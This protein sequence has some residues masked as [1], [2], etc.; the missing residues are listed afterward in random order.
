MF[1]FGNQRVV[2]I[3][4]VRIG[5]EPGE[6][7]T[8]LIGS[9]FYRGHKVVRDERNGIFDRDS[10]ESLIMKIE[11]LS[12]R[13]GNPGLVDVVLMS[14]RAVEGYI[15]FVADTTDKPFLIDSALPEVR[16]SAVRYAEEVGVAERIIYNSISPESKIEELDAL[17]NSEIRSAIALTYTPRLTS[18]SSRIDAFKEL[19]PEIE[20]AGITE[21]LV[22]TFVMDVPSLPVSAVAG[23]KI[24]KAFGYPTGS[25]AHNAIASWRGFE[26][27]FGK[28][29][30]KYAV[31]TADIMQV[32]AGSDFVLYGPVEDAEKIFPAMY[33]LD[34]AYRYF[35]RSGDAIEF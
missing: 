14:E 3:A 1:R 29:S 23:M 22:D 17:K 8:A 19:L 12:D 11:E 9:I 20:R 33:V 32:F 13:T 27:M 25:G 35:M 21:I 30:E 26:K 5:G 10:A 4:G 18:V 28:E 2:D 31:L 34:T 7:P 6:N 24:K 15:E 16:I